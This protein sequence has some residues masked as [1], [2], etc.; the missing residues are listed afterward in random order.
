MTEAKIVLKNLAYEQHY[1]IIPSADECLNVC[2]FRNVRGLKR[3]LMLGARNTVSGDLRVACADL[4]P[5]EFAEVHSA[6]RVSFSVT[7]SGESRTGELCNAI[8]NIHPR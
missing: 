8:W 6:A 1:V 4:T 2:L 3:L 7:L 5:K